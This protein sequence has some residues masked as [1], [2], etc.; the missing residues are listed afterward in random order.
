[1]D[2]ESFSTKREHSRSPEESGLWTGG[3]TE[4]GE[5]ELSSNL[6]PQCPIKPMK[7]LDPFVA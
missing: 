2:I 6:I 4:K 3:V 5:S 1:L 7:N